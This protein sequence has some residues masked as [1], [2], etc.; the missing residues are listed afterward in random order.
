MNQRNI[1]QTHICLVSV[2]LLLFI[3]IIILTSDLLLSCIG[4]GSIR[5]RSPAE[6]ENHL[7]WLASDQSTNC[8]CKYC[9]K[10]ST[11][12]KELQTASQSSKQ[13]TPFNQRNY[14]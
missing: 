11:P 9:S 4:F 13:Q 6:F 2:K 8:I 12:R 10:N 3:I 1:G 5:F 7:L 14:H